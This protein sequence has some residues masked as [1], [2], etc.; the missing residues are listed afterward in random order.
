MDKYLFENRRITT[1]K[2]GLKIEA[3]G[4]GMQDIIQTFPEAE[5]DYNA[6]ILE[7]DGGNAIKM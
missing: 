4:K 7:E 1:S 3:K 2:I 6:I 5:Q